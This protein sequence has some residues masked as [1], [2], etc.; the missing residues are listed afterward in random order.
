MADTAI[1]LDTCFLIRALVPGTDADHRLRKWLRDGH[2]LCMDSIAWTEFL[3]GPVQP[4]ERE[5]AE[6]VV[7][8]RVSYGEAEAQRA[9]ELFNASGRRRGTR[10]DCMIAATAVERDAA[11]A[12]LNR[13][14]FRCFEAFGL[15]LA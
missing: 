1:H 13:D 2:R 6:Q 14:D 12:T 9:A 10:A 4:D 7:T 3:C 15:R 5:L 11:L 8:E